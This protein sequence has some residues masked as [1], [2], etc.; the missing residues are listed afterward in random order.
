MREVLSTRTDQSLQIEIKMPKGKEKNFDF[1]GIR[2]GKEIFKLQ[3][4]LK[5]EDKRLHSYSV[6]YPNP[7]YE[8]TCQE[9]VRGK[10]VFKVREKLGN[11]ILSPGKIFFL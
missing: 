3:H 6:H 1:A 9:I 5:N 7:I 10:K 8:A 11:F 4:I 2:R